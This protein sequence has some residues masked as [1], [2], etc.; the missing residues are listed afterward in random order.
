M[1]RVKRGLTQR[2]S[3]ISN[4]NVV[5]WYSHPSVMTVRVEE[6]TS[7]V[8]IWFAKDAGIMAENFPW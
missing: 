3:P 7:E 2:Y 8:H 4:T 6:K 1:D 5:Y